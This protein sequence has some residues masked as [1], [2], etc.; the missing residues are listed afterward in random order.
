MS[1]LHLYR[2]STGTRGPN[3]S[4]KSGTFESVYPRYFTPIFYF[5]L[6]YILHFKKSKTIMYTPF[7]GFRHIKSKNKKRSIWMS[8]ETFCVKMHGLAMDGLKSLE[9]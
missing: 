1:S 6:S 8:L 7:C 4:A 9:I 5:F 3:E 2:G